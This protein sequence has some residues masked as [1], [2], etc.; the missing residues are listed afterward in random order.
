MWYDNVMKY[1]PLFIA[2]LLCLPHSG[3]AE[4]VKDSIYYTMDDG[5]M[6]PDEMEEEAQYIFRQCTR[7]P[8]MKSLYNCECLTGAFL[9]Q[10]EAQGPMVTQYDI[11]KKVLR[12]PANKCANGPE[13]ANYAYNTCTAVEKS[14]DELA[15]PKSYE[16]RCACVGNKVARDFEKAPMLESSYMEAL[17][18]AAIEYCRDPARERMRNARD[19]NTNSTDFSTLN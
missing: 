6:S 3:Q 5:I 10:R 19:N 4:Q 14:I 11:M 16:A 7:Q 1:I 2:L 17:T 8:Y 9:I 18:N 13:I 15:A 12:N